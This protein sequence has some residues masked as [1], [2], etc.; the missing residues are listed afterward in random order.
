MTRPTPQAEL[1][2]WHAEAV[3]LVA[4]GVRLEVPE[5]PQCGWYRRRLVPGGPLVAVRISM[6]ADVDADGELTGDETLEAWLGGNWRDPQEEWTYCAGRPVTEAE[7]LYME[8]RAHHATQFD[9]G[10]P[11]ASP[12]KRIDWLACKLPT[13]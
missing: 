8:A 12:R 6:R 9:P 4:H 2:R 10:S 7:F 3:V 11:F 1:Y 5:E 13:F